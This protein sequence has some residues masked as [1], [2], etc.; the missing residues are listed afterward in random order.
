MEEGLE[1]VLDT[2]SDLADAAMDG[3]GRDGEDRR[4][5]SDGFRTPLHNHKEADAQ[6]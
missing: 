2:L 6:K 5:G 3:G 1:T 4:V